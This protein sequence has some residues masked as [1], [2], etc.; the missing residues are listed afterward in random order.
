M[1]SEKEQ[2]FLLDKSS[3]I[4]KFIDTLDNAETFKMRH[5]RQENNTINEGMKGMFMICSK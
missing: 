5:R 2:E 3:T 4:K 1:I